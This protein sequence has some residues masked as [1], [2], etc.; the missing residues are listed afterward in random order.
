MFMREH[1]L[2]LWIIEGET[3]MRAHN[4]IV[5]FYHDDGAFLSYR[6]CPPEATGN[7]LFVARH[8]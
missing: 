6:G 2:L 3:Y 7:S 4:G 8:V 5:Y 1:V